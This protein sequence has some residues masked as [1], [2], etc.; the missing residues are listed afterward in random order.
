MAVMTSWCT[1]ARMADPASADAVAPRDWGPSGALAAGG[2]TQTDE[3]RWT[4]MSSR[5]M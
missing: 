1:G 3:G 4:G 2:G 5:W